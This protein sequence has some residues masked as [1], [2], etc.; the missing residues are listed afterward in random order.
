MKLMPAMTKEK[1]SHKQIKIDEESN[2]GPLYRKVTISFNVT[3]ED[4]DLLQEG[5]IGIHVNFRDS[6]I[7]TVREPWEWAVSSLADR[8][9]RLIPLGELDDRLGEIPQ[10]RPVVV[11]CRTGQRS[12]E[13]A[14]RL[15]GAGFGSVSNLRGGLIA[16]AEEVEP[17]LPVV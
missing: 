6:S 16:W 9:A 14:R 11:Y 5:H 2:V 4:F 3:Q 1:V 12:M 10:D 13:A 17:G 7:N 8:G 15:S